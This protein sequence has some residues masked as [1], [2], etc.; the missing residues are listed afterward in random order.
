M[1]AETRFDNIPK[2]AINLSK[3]ALLDGLGVTMAG[4]REPLSR[5]L[6]KYLIEM[7]GKP[8]AA[9]KYEHLLHV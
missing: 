7:G 4:S 8:T 6:Q 3:R 2:Q 5:I 9:P 1:I